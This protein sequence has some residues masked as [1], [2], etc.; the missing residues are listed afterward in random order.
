M[1]W[2]CIGI[3]VISVWAAFWTFV[4]CFVCQKLGILKYSDQVQDEGIDIHHHIEKSS[5]KDRMSVVRQTGAM[6]TTSSSDQ[7]VTQLKDL[8]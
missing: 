1:G 4:I 7:K 2:Q 6:S 8:A 3:I 5:L